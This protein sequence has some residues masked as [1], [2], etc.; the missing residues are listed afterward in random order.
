MLSGELS[1]GN[2]RDEEGRIRKTLELD[3]IFSAI[4]GFARVIKYKTSESEESKSNKE[5]NQ[6]L[7]IEEG[8]FRNGMKNGYCRVVDLTA[9]TV[10]CGFFR[11]NSP[12]GKYVKW[13]KSDEVVEEG[14]FRGRGL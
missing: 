10:E 8:F 11:N 7:S 2:H 4:N 3:S 1:E 14:I 6:L 13:N 12:Y 9:D 5:S